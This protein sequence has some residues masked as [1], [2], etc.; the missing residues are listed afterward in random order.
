MTA[1][2]ALSDQGMKAMARVAKP[3]KSTK[4]VGGKR[5]PGRPATQAAKPTLKATTAAKPTIAAAA[6]RRASAAAAPV[7]KLNVAELRLLVEKLEDNEA[8]LRA[9]NRE[10]GRAAKTAAARIADLEQQVAGFEAKAAE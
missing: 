6:P 4:P 9:K 7:P 1:A 2:P 8:T 5:K 3:T 10:A